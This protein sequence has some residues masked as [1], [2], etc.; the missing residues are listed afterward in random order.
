VRIAALLRKAESTDNE[1]EADAFLQAAQ[2]LA[3][4]ASVDL[5]VARAHTADTER[6]VVPTQRTVEIG[7]AGKRGLRTYVQLYLAIA[8][9]NSVTCD[10]ARN[11][12]RVFA[13]GFESDLDT[14][15]ALYSSLVVQMVRAC[16][17]YLR[18][19][20]RAGDV[21]L[22]R[23]VVTGPTGRRS[24]RWVQKPVHAST[25]RINFQEAFAERIGRRLTQA[26]QAAQAEVVQERGDPGVA[27]VLRAKE[28]ELTEHYRAQ[29]TARGTWGGY[30]ASAGWSESSRAAGDRAGRTAR[31]GEQQSIGGHRAALGR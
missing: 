1:H 11:S 25:A 8:R 5:A 31:I 21:A 17:E 28:L 29:S 19:P 27:I 26:Q 6:R 10:I 3:T 7:Q 13:Y 23:E 30:R 2:R 18:S 4:L 22:S 14:V 24:T 9:A 16:D 12:T 15:Q 20:E